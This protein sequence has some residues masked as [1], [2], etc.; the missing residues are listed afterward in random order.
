MY[1]KMNYRFSNK[2]LLTNFLHEMMPKTLNLEFHVFGRVCVFHS[3][4]HVCWNKLSVHIAIPMCICNQQHIETIE[5]KAT[6]AFLTGAI[7]LLVIQVC[8]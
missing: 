5:S 3:P 8:S 7:V 1:Q 2:I 4:M 6:C